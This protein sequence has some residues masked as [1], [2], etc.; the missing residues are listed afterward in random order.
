MFRALGI[1]GLENENRVP[2][3]GIVY[4]GCIEI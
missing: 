2:V 1:C 3:K 4:S